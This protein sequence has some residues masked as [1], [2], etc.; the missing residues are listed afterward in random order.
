M[1]NFVPAS[2]LFLHKK[3]KKQNIHDELINKNKIIS[4]VA[5]DYTIIVD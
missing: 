4:S 3:E 2:Y 1:N 5:G